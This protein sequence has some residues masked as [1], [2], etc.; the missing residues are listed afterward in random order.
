MDRDFKRKLNE[1]NIINSQWQFTNQ[2][3]LNVEHIGTDVPTGGRSGDI[4]IGE[5]VIWVN[6]QGVWKYVSLTTP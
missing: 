1:P 3:K 2:L 6:D 4:K 5:D